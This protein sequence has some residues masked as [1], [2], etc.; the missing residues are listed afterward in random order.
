MRKSFYI[1]YR[2]RTFET[3]WNNILNKTNRIILLISNQVFLQDK[4]LTDSIYCSLIPLLKILLL[5]VFLISIFT[6]QI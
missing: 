5:F 3:D 4:L 2:K 1:F 6:N